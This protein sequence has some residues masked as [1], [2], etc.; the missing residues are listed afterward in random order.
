M[1]LTKMITGR[2]RARGHL[3][4]DHHRPQISPGCRVHYGVAT[5]KC[6]KCR[7]LKYASY[8]E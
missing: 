8:Y 6:R 2:A 7:D 5:L 3:A 4:L 1:R